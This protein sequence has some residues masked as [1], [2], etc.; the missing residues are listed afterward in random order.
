MRPHTQV[1]NHLIRRYPF[2]SSIPRAGH[3]HQMS[4]PENKHEVS[5]NSSSTVWGINSQSP[6]VQLSCVFAQGEVFGIIY[7]SFLSSTCSSRWWFTIYMWFRLNFDKQQSKNK[8]NKKHTYR[9]YCL[10]LFNVFLKNKRLQ[11]EFWWQRYDGWSQNT[12]LWN[13]KQNIK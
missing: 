2:M 6:A 13:L 10:N 9:P 4:P 11:S 5:C 3:A 12:S 1:R 8:T 7:T